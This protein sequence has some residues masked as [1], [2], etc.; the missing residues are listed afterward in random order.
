MQGAATTVYLALHPD[1]KGVSGKYFA[2]CDEAT[3]TPVARDAELAKKLW[4]FSEELVEN[5]SK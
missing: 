1:A 3:P 5:R 2:G 4:A